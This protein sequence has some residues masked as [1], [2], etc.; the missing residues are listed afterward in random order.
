MSRL[1]SRLWPNKAPMK[2]LLGAVLLYA[3]TA[4]AAESVAGL[5]L[6]QEEV[7]E[8]V[9]SPCQREARWYVEGGPALTTL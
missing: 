5:Y 1:N 3:S 8:S 4:A 9:F 2:K 6:R 7:D